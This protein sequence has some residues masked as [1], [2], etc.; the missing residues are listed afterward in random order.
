[1]EN[2]IYESEMEEPE[3]NARDYKPG[4]GRGVNW[5]PTKLARF[6]LLVDGFRVRGVEGGV[7]RKAGVLIRGSSVPTKGEMGGEFPLS[8][9]VEESM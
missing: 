5:S 1:M 2:R 3:T 8:P 6:L 4:D 9:G 7:G